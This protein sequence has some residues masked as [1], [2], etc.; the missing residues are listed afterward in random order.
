ML[1]TLE[2]SLYGRKWRSAQRGEHVQKHDFERGLRRPSCP[3]KTGRHAVELELE[4]SCCFKRRIMAQ[5]QLVRQRT[6]HRAPL[7][8]DLASQVEGEAVA[9]RTARSGIYPRV[10]AQGPFEGLPVQRKDNCRSPRH[11]PLGTQQ[12]APKAQELRPH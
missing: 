5:R 12:E 4:S 1:V 8:D 7:V 10:S 11:L 6:F 3:V 9:E 2:R